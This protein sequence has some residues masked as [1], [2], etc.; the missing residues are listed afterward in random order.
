MD[1]AGR[2][3]QSR[4]VV[5]P[6][7]PTARPR[8]SD[9][10]REGVWLALAKPPQRGQKNPAESVTSTGSL[11]MTLAT[12][13]STMSN[14]PPSSHP[15]DPA[16]MGQSAP[17]MPVDQAAVKEYLRRDASVSSRVTASGSDRIRRR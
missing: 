8:A 9:A 14:K 17:R 10:D 13:L 5:Q 6:T 3:A 15:P 1:A 2:S 4:V 16:P 7:G 12:Q 11:I